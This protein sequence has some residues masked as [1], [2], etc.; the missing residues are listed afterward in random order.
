M[1]AAQTKHLLAQEGLGNV[2]LVGA[3][4]VIKKGSVQVNLPKKRGAAAAGFDKA[5][6]GFHEKLMQVCARL[7]RS[8]LDNAAHWG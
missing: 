4:T 5:L 6:A 3:S 8:R 7:S 1:C 2:F